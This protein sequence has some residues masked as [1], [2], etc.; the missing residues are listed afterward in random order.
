MNALVDDIEKLK[1]E[2]SGLNATE[3]AMNTCATTLIIFGG[4]LTMLAGKAVWPF[5]LVLTIPSIVVWRATVDF[6]KVFP[7][8]E[9]QY[10]LLGFGPGDTVVLPPEPYR[11]GWKCSVM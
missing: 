6:N 5:L 11:P 4:G 1:V 3:T 2:R 9:G 7:P 8:R 10:R